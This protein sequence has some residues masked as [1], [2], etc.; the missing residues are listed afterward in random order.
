[1]RTNRTKAITRV[2]E[3]EF[4]MEARKLNLVPLFSSNGNINQLL[5]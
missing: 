1:M 4:Y 2:L 3:V 5:T